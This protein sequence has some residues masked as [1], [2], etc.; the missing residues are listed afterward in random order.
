VDFKKITTLVVFLLA[1]FVALYL[2]IAAATS[3]TEVLAWVGGAIFLIICLRLGRNIWIL[4]PATLGM[5]GYFNFIPGSPAPWHLM[6]AVVGGFTLLRIATRQQRLHLRWTGMETALLL[7]ALTILQAFFRNPI[8]LSILGG[9]VSGGKP[10]FVYGVAF[11]AYLLISTADTDMSGWRWAITA[12]IVLTFVDITINIISGF[13]PDFARLVI[14]IYSNVSFTAANEIRYTVDASEK[15]ITEFGALGIFLGTIAS[16]MWRPLAALDIRKPWR[17]VAAIGALTATVLG[18]F[19]GA[20]ARLFVDFSL[21]SLLRR[22]PLDVLVVGCIGVVMTAILLI[23]VPT[24]TLPFSVQRLLT[25]LP[26]VEVRSEIAKDAEGSNEFRFEMWRQALTTDRYIS[27]KLLGDGFQYSSSEMRARTAVMYGDF[28]GTGG[29]TTEEMFM[30]TGSYHG[31]HAETIRFTGVV[32]LIAAT[33]TL[34]VFAVFASRCIRFYRDQ[35]GWGLVLFFCMPFLIHPFWYW[36]VF[37]EYRNDFAVLIASAGMIKLLY[38]LALR[39][40]A[41]QKAANAVGLLQ[42]TAGS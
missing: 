8:G 20:A 21:G 2:G 16:T 27:N 13:S 26:G 22:K 17:A 40:D 9:D 15:R 14:R 31:F 33:A 5:Q 37:G 25:I 6:T 19:R 35:A 39:Q 41:E 36:L 1:M 10:Y 7:V 42:I 12:L 4:I 18:G 32:G 24:T 29:M 28:R 11:I 34:I 23:A 30:A 38:A 3:L